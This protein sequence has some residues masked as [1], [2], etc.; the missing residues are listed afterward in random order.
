MVIAVLF[1]AFRNAT[2]VS[3]IQNIVQA[4]QQVMV[5]DVIHLGNY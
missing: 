4:E 2:K 3:Y 5:D 1:C